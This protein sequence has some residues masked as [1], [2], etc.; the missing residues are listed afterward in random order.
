M[1]ATVPDPVIVAYRLVAVLVALVLAAATMVFGAPSTGAVAAGKASRPGG[2]VVSITDTLSQAHLSVAPGERVTWVNNDTETHRVVSNRGASVEFDSGVLEPGE[3]WSRTFRSA[4]DVVYHDHGDATNPAYLGMVMVERSHSSGS[5]SSAGTGSG[6]FAADTATT[7]FASSSATNSSKGFPT[8]PA[9]FASSSAGPRQAAA[10][11]PKHVFVEIHNKNEFRPGNVT[12]AKGGTVT[13]FNDHSD[14]HTAS[15]AGGINSGR[16]HRDQRYSKT[17]DTPGIYDYV[18]AFHDRMKGKVTVLR[19][20]GSEPPPPPPGD[21]GGTPPP[22]GA[23]NKTVSITSNFNPGSV[24]VPAGGSV[25]WTNNDSSPH[26]AT[27]SAF[28]SGN[29]NNGQSFTKK[30]TTAG[31]F[32]YVCSYHSNMTG[33]VK[34]TNGSGDVPPP[35]PGGGGGGGNPPPPPGDGGGSPPP[36]PPGGGGGGGQAPAQASV[37]IND[38]LF[39]PKAVTIRAGGKVTW[40]NRGNPHTATGSAFD[41]GNLNTGQS[42]THRF[43]KAGTYDYVCAYHPDMTGTIKV[44]NASGGV[45]P[46]SPGTPPGGG[47]N[48]GGNGGGG[49]TGGGGGSIGGGGSAVGGGSSPSAQT[50]TVTMG[51]DSFNPASLDARVGDT[52]VWKNASPVP[53]NVNGGSAFKSPT[54]MGGQSFETVLRQQGTI[55][56]KCDFHSGMTGTI[57]VAAAPAGTKLPPPSAGGGLSGSASGSLG[58]TSAGSSSG[59]SS[60]GSAGAPAPGAESHTISMVNSTFDPQVLQARVGDEVTWVNEDPVPHN[61]TGGPL[62]SGMMMGGAEFTTVL[63]ETGTVEYE[64]T[65][66]PGMTG[67]LEVAEALPGTKVPP[68]S[69]STTSGGSSAAPGDAAGG[70]QSAPSA[71]PEEGA[72]NHTVE[73]DNMVFNPDTLEANVGDTVTFVNKEAAPHTATAEDKSWDSG[74]M[75]QGQEWTLKLDRVGTIKYV[76]IYHPGMDGTLIVK[77][78][79]EEVAP[80]SAGSDDAAATEGTM[81][82]SQIAGLSS[83]WLVL[84][85]FLAGLQ[86][87]SRFSSRRKPEQVAPR[88]PGGYSA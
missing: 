66:H 59:S 21:G 37:T 7:S 18:C 82:A 20:D 27:G 8:S 54:V 15:G 80:A 60:G 62:D 55:S 79:G 31:T 81:P 30:F 78:K 73:M 83:G 65:L 61:V 32:T 22:P 52:V 9:T 5:S 58:S 56:Y 64:C 44:T 63:T 68:A 86:L 40:T 49:G 87:Q 11:G 25:T 76:C 88:P 26:T 19:A 17:F 39:S 71:E 3:R 4:G 74:N 28:D 24:T 72:K 47:G 51:A 70:A 77:P 2:S 10:D 12:V 67:T 23:N 6:V 1:S 38:N 41:S 16:L 29:L 13:W 14:D 43:P 69:S 50:H 45:P 42:F 84:L 53:H 46:G 85:A 36:P 48:G 35:P 75:N 57:K 34:V 33:T